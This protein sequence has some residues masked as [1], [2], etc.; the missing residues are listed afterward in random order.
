MT[1]ISI[2]FILIGIY[3]QEY[4]IS[5]MSIFFIVVMLLNIKIYR[6]RARFFLYDFSADT[7]SI[8]IIYYDKNESKQ[9][10]IKWT[11]LD[12]FFGRLKSERYLV[13]WHKN[14]EILKFFKT[15]ANHAGKFSEIQ[16]SFLKYIPQS[17]IIRRKNIMVEELFSTKN[18][19][20]KMFQ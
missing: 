9:I 3:S 15:F 11:E 8:N 5:F 17:R 10:S 14:I 4:V 18:Y 2:S 16:N 1:V 7:E 13:I 20:F 12:F 6:N 19:Y